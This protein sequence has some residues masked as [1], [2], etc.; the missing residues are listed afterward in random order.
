MKI[1]FGKDNSVYSL[2]Q[3]EH[4]QKHLKANVQ[5]IPNLLADVKRLYNVANPTESCVVVDRC[6]KF[7]ILTNDLYRQ[8][9]LLCF[10]FSTVTDMSA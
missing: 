3:P 1:Y 8:E 7:S 5:T 10:T 9:I 4:I 6:D 2:V